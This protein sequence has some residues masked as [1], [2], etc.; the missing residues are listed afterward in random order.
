SGIRVRGAVAAGI[1]VRASFLVVESLEDES[2]RI[3][4]A[5]RYVDVVTELGG[6][7]RFASKIA[8]YDSPIVPLS[9]IYPL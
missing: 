6:R 8:V 5:G 9:L 7:L 2:T 4:V 1:E 3:H